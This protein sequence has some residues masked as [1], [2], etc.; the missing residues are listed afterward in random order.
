M[1][2]VLFKAS[3]NCTIIMV[4]MMVSNLGIV[5]GMFHVVGWVLGGVEAVC[6]SILVGTVL[7]SWQD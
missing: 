1:W 3:F 7:G 5:V 2:V 4:I 6:L